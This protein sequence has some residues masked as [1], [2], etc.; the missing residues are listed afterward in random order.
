VEKERFGMDKKIAFDPDL[1]NQTIWDCFP[2]LYQ[3]ILCPKNGINFPLNIF[4]LKNHNQWM[5]YSF[6]RNS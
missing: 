2:P 3:Q 6:M 1:P 5:T 4:I